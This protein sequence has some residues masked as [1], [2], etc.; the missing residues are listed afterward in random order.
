MR[1][2][3]GS[4]TDRAGGRGKQ[5]ALSEK[6]LLNIRADSTA[7]RNSRLQASEMTMGDQGP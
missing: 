1:I 3:G 4:V 7:L 2:V 6:R 5:Q